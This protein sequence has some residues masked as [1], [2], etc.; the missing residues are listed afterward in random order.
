MKNSKINGSAFTIKKRGFD[1]DDVICIVSGLLMSVIT[2]IITIRSVKYIL[3]SLPM[4]IVFVYILLG[5]L[6]RC[7][8]KK[9]FINFSE[10]GITCLDI[11]KHY[12]FSYEWSEIISVKL[13][14]IRSARTTSYHLTI[15]T[16]DSLFKF[17]ISSFDVSILTLEKQ[18]EKFVPEHLLELKKT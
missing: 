15:C 7:N 11:I 12:N 2:I 9:S 6:H 8:D 13:S 14:E 17:Q 1:I 5:I 16:K 10:R 18:L 4:V 3:L